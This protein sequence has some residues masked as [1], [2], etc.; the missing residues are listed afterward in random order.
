MTEREETTI[1][2]DFLPN[3]Y[4]FGERRLPIAQAIGKNYFTLLEL[5]PRKGVKLKIGE[6]VYIGT[7]KRD[8]IYYILGRLPRE[9]LTN[10]AKIELEEFINK[11]IEEK[12]K[13][14]VEFFNNAQAI[15]TRLHQLELLPGFGK[16]HMKAIIEDRDKGGNFKS[17]EEIKERI[18]NIPDPKK[19]VKKRLVEELTEKT[20]YK[21]FVN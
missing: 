5:V 17:F 20:R 8:K 13:N 3:G 6:E 10:T 19:A 4:P 1:I 11:S 18:K 16:K 12:E 15:N 2:L 7:D 9:K 21:L 14:F